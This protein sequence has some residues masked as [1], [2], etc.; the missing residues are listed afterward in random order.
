MHPWSPSDP[1]RTAAAKARILDFKTT[2]S[3]FQKAS[4]TGTEPG[5]AELPTVV[6][7]GKFTSAVL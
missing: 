5:K 4:Q 6:P 7:I 2:R 3:E 1:S